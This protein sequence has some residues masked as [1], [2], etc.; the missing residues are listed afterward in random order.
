MLFVT[1]IYN[2]F[3]FQPLNL[4]STRKWLFM[5]NDDD[6]DKKQ[7]LKNDDSD[8]DITEKE[9]NVIIDLYG[10]K[11]LYHSYK[12][13]GRFIPKNVLQSVYRQR[14]DAE[15]DYIF[16]LY[17]EQENNPI[18]PKQNIFEHMEYCY[19]TMKEQQQ[20]PSSSVIPSI[21]TKADIE[22]GQFYEHYSY[23]LPY[24]YYIEQIVRGQQVYLSYLGSIGLTLYYRSLVPGFSI[25][26]IA[27]VLNKTAYL[28]P[29]SNS[30]SITNRLLDTGAFI[31]SILYNN[32]ECLLPITGDGWKSAIQVRILHAKVRYNIL[33]QRRKRQQEKDE[34]KKQEQTMNNNNSNNDNNNTSSSDNYDNNEN[35]IPINQEDLA[36]VLLAFSMNTILGCEMIL[37]FPIPEDQQLDLLAFWRYIGWLLGVD[38]IESTTTNNVNNNN[39]N[40]H[41]ER[42]NH[43]EHNEHNKSNVN[44]NS[45]DNILHINHHPTSDSV[46]VHTINDT[47]GFKNDYNIN[48][49]SDNNI[50]HNFDTS[51]SIDHNNNNYKPI[52]PCGPGWII[53]NPNPLQHAISFSYSSMIH[54]MKPNELSVKICHHLLRMGK[55]YNTNNKDNDNQKSSSSDASSNAS[56]RNGD[57]INDH[58]FYFRSYQCRRFIGNKLANALQLPYHPNWLVRMKLYTCSNIY[59]WILR[60]YTYAALP[61]SPF[62][63]YIIQCHQRNAKLIYEKW[64]NGTIRK[65]RNNNN[66]NVKNKDHNNNQHGVVDEETDDPNTIPSTSG[67]SCPFAMVAPPI[68]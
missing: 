8:V 32:K 56:K 11:I 33:K 16:Q 57:M 28:A 58:W 9:N 13:G 19:H 30:Q 17:D 38:C 64:K 18:Q 31:C 40:E 68:Q 15:L 23:Q 6:N 45:D 48:N 25:P 35:D 44:S 27:N 42:N 61:Y 39:N 29:P 37:G 34:E 7:K 46:R 36:A 41:N 3:T 21:L 26:K 20:N 52:D 53:D 51:S 62:R 43:N 66:N 12:D 60:L 65:S 5:L 10:E 22:L 47:T 63:K 55:T 24:W 2:Y 14:G 67:S 59:L 4:Y 50:S 49:I 54:L 1:T